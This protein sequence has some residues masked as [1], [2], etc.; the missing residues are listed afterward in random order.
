M[1][2]NSVYLPYLI[3]INGTHSCAHPLYRVGDDKMY[4]CEPCIVMTDALC[5]V[6]LPNLDYNAG[7]VYQPLQL[8]PQSRLFYSHLNKHVKTQGL[9]V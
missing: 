1:G 2:F 4:C 5:I 9:I 3:N 7:K 6:A 8:R